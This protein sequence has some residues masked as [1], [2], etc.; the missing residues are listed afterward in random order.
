MRLGFVGPEGVE[1]V[2]QDAQPGRGLSGVQRL[3]QVDGNRRGEHVVDGVSRIVGHHPYGH[4]TVAVLD[5]S[6][7]YHEVGEVT[8][9]DVAISSPLDCREIKQF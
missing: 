5:E 1:Q 8:S 4:I 7:R 3:G 2:F 6:Q 9:A